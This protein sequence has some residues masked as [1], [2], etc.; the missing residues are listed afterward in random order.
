MIRFVLKGLL[1]DPSR[2]R[3]PVMM[4]AAGTFLTVF[5]QSWMQGVIG[6]MVRTN[7]QFDTGHVKVMTRAY[8]ESADQ[9]P[10]DLALLGVGELLGDLRALRPD[11]IWTPRIRFGGLLDV[12]DEHGETRAQGPVI[13]LG[14]DLAGPGTDEP[15]I[16]NLEKA[17]TRGRL[18]EQ[19]DEILV[20]EAF[21]RKLGVAPGERATLLG[22]TMHGAM[23][24]HNFTVVGT[25]QFGIAALDR[26]AMIADLGGVRAALDMADGAGE[27][28]GYS[29]D[30][31]YADREMVELAAGFRE[32]FAQE[33]GEFA[34]LMVSLREQNGLAEY[35]D[36]TAVAAAVIVG[37]FVAAMSVVLWNAALMNG[38]RRYGEIGVRL[39]IGEPKGTLF[40]HMLLESALV[41]VA[42]SVVG[43]ALGLAVSYYLQ[44]NGIDISS[45]MRRS[46]VMMVSEMRARVTG[47]S[48]VLGFLPGLLAPML[49]TAFAGVGIYRRQTAQLFKELEA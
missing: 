9:V 15:G 46:S 21:A 11:M 22:S 18:P 43:T 35:L 24:M 14:V 2:S 16:L 40:R 27:I 7:A 19:A 17:L 48:Y 33:E 29:R 39:A 28:V 32:R 13:G 8:R 36:L 31:V 30:M 20:S 42:G 5:L 45:M 23:A 25:V 10:N 1:R 47:L 37:V 26:G 4:V 34:P 12:P 38:L 44:Y 41:G 6:D 3:L 49:G